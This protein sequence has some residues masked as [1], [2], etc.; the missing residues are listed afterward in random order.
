MIGWPRWVVHIPLGVFTEMEARQAA[1]NIAEWLR[2][3]DVR[4]DHVS[5]EI[6]PE[7]GQTTERRRVFCG[8]LVD[9]GRC[10]LPESHPDSECSTEGPPL[11]IAS[12]EAIA[13]I[14]RHRAE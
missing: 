1:E 13:N 4:V 8:V 7:D 12:A 5:V 10:D 2:Q 11:Q 6:S 9:G 3:L 14:L